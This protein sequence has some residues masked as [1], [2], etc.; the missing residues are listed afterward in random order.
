MTLYQTGTSITK[1]ESNAN[2]GLRSKKPSYVDGD[3]EVKNIF[4]S[5]TKPGLYFTGERER[6]RGRIG[7]KTSRR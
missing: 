3:S 2:S 7:P 6:E 5:L 1:K 4:P